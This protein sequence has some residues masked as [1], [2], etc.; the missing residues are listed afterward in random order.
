[1]SL[2]RACLS[3]GAPGHVVVTED[4]AKVLMWFFSHS[5]GGSAALRG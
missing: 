4:K 2:W 1:M 5:G 3:A